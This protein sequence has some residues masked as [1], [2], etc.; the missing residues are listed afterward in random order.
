MEIADFVIVGSSGGG[1]TIAWVLAKAGFKVV[2]L[3]QGTDWYERLHDDLDLAKVDKHNQRLYNASSH[4]ENRFRIERP[5]FKRRLRGDYNTFRRRDDHV[6][7]P[8]YAGWTGSMLGGG[9]VIWGAWAFR[10]LPI[11]F[12]LG[13]HYEATGQARQLKEWGYDVVDWPVSY[14]QMEPYYNVAETLL[15]VS[16]N[17]KATTQ[18]ITKTKWY[19]QFKDAPYWGPEDWDPK[20]E[21][22]CPPMPLT[23]V[24]AYVARGF[25]QRE[26]QVAPL[27]SGMVSNKK[28]TVESAAA[29]DYRTQDAI[30]AAMK[31]WVGERPEFWKKT[32]EEIWSDSIRSA[33][34]MCG[35][36]GEY[37]CWGVDG[38][39]S[40]S[41]VS[42]LREIEGLRNVD[43]ITGA[44]AYEVV[45]N[46]S[47]RRATGVKYLD[48]S[49]PEHPKPREQRA[50]F[51]IVSCGAVQSARLLLMSGPPHGLGNRRDVVGRYATFHL[52]G[53]GAKCVLD[54]RFQGNLRGELAH[55]GNVVTYDNYFISDNE[56]E[57][58]K[59]T[60][61]KAGTMVSTAKKNPLENAIGTVNRAK[62]TGD[63]LLEAME[64]HSR[65][66]ELRLTGDDLPMYRN[67]V[68]LDPRYVDEY[69]FPV[70]RITRDFG[71]AERKM[72]DL[73]RPN[74]QA[75]LDQEGCLKMV[76]NPDKP[77][78]PPKPVLSSSTNAL[79]DLIGDHQMGT[80]RMGND[81]T[82]SVLDANCRL[83]DCPNVFVVDTSFMPT[84]FGLNPMVT[85]VANALRVGTWIVDESRRGKGLD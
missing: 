19:Q 67:R 26:W 5:E 83:H 44:K 14:K 47:T 75:V 85:V 22:P 55:T 54:R 58:E 73:S 71:P 51:V 62:R 49:D 60:W 30:Q 33:C 38:P 41:R 66:I 48:V 18:A 1:G 15:A 25:E 42:T 32:P 76:T 2:V 12:V 36:C 17:R 29:R 59:G 78:D 50:K 53:L 40:G 80:C 39:K 24:G 45:Y 31:A 72:F 52:F 13:Q 4:D 61:W 9:S 70:A 35:F 27:P 10:A 79:V 82:T 56:K 37:L 28:L 57:P 64:D 65:T 20:F 43:I 77:S 8:F 7:E 21:F 81:P 16:G 6:A 69:G 84:G 46:P 11:D 68:D 74:M 3:E 63:K 34:N 23:P